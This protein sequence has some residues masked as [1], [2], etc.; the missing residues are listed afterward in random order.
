[1]E[2]IIKGRFKL[3]FG[4]VAFEVAYKCCNMT[5]QSFSVNL[6]SDDNSAVALQLSDVK[7]NDNPEI[8]I[9][10]LKATS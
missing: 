3:E 10:K 7:K 6:V 5:N 1:V 8:L 9:Y 4:P 2:N